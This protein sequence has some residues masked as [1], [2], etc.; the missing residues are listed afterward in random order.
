VLRKIENVPTGPNNRPKLVVKITGTP[1]YWFVSSPGLPRFRR[2]RRNVD[3]EAILQSHHCLLT[4]KCA[5]WNYCGMIED[6]AGSNT[7]VVWRITR[8]SWHVNFLGNS[9]VFFISITR[10]VRWLFCG[11][12]RD[13]F[14]CTLPL[15]FTSGLA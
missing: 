13:I 4:F 11:L 1:F 9:C 5:N 6:S 2:M 7:S 15:F 14:Q 3:W 10:V 8:L 12:L